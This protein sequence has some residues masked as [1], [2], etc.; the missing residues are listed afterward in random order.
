ML[1]KI[2]TYRNTH[3]LYYG[4]CKID[5]VQKWFQ[6]KVSKTYGD[7][8][9]Y[10]LH[11]NIYHID[12]NMLT[13]KNKDKYIDFINT[14]SS[15]KD[16]YS[17]YEK[18]VIVLYNIETL[19]SGV[20]ECIPKFMD[21]H[22]ETCIFILFT[23]SYNKITTNIKSRC[24][25]LRVPKQKTITYSDKLTLYTKDVYKSPE[26][27]TLDKIISIYK[28][29]DITSKDIDIIREISYRYY[30]Y[31]CNSTNIQRKLCIRL[32]NTKIPNQIKYKIIDKIS[33]LNHLYQKSYKQS[34]Y[35]EYMIIDIYSLIAKYTHYL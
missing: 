8:I 33:K 25:C 2:L 6:C 9:K 31:Y 24:L 3:V 15:S 29:N 16:Y 20:Q 17:D 34:I 21:K 32:L 35:L 14:I 10:I 4:F 28:S 27:L 22:Y 19:S 1:D 30:M 26:Q 7:P 13:N 18:K 5:I 11:E 12:V 23:N